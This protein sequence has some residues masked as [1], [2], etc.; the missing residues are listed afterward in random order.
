[1][2]RRLIDFDVTKELNWG[3]YFD[4]TRELNFGIDFDVTSKLEA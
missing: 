4:V 3:V 2:K 1:M